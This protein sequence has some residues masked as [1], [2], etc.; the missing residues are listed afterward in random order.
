ML[1]TSASPSPPA[2][3]VDADPPVLPAHVRQYGSRALFPLNNTKYSGRLCARRSAGQQL[4]ELVGRNGPREVIALGVVAAELG[5][6][7]ELL[8]G[9]DALGE[10]RDAERR[11]E[12][13]KRGDDRAR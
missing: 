11:R 13:G 9:L 7:L 6:R 3:A 10:A 2:S 1:L 8:G 12:A 5:Q 4:S